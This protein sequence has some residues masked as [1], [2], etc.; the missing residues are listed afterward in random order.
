MQPWL[1]V[2]VTFFD[3]TSQGLGPLVVAVGPDVVP[4]V[5]LGALVVDDATVVGIGTKLNEKYCVFKGILLFHI[6]CMQNNTVYLKIYVGQIK[7]IKIISNTYRNQSSILQVASQDSSPRNR[8][9]SK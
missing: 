7:K 5:L 8:I 6:I 4:I 1:F 9:Y 3:T 2:T